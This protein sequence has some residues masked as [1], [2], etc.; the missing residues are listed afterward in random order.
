MKGRHYLQ[1][2]LGEHRAFGSQLQGWSCA[3]YAAILRAI[4]GQDSTSWPKVRILGP[5]LEGA[6]WCRAPGRI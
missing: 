1:P 6:S 5:A 2:V 3:C 4:A